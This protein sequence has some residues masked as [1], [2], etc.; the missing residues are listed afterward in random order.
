MIRIGLI[1]GM[2]SGKSFIAK[3]FGFPVFNADKE[4]KS[5][6]KTDKACFYGLKKRLPKY[7]S[8]F[9]IRKSELIKAIASNKKNL[10]KVSSVVHPIV[11][12][13]MRNFLRK[14]KNFKMVILDI[15]LLIENKLNRKDDVLIY[16][17]SDQKKII[18]RLKKRKNYNKQI[19]NR[20]KNNQFELS[21][22]SKLAKYKINNNFSKNIMK[23]KVIKLK[24]KILN[25]RNS[26]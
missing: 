1:G 17:N 9:P 24:N 23:K 2:A 22:K 21:K 20:L 13:R 12:R 5:I 26:T 7:I 8:S 11:R 3:L 4:V 14:K 16:V 25:E 15:P 18:D 10:N 6:Y 19:F